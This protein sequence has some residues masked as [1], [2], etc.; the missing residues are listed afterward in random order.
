MSLVE[1]RPQTSGST[2]VSHASR[3]RSK[4]GGLH[5]QVDKHDLVGQFAMAPAT[6]TTVVTTTTT[7]TVKYPPFIMRAPNK[8]HCLDPKQYPLQDSPTPLSLKNIIFKL[9]GKSTTFQEAPDSTMA[10]ELFQEEHKSIQRANGKL[11]TI[12][13]DDGWVEPGPSRP[14]NIIARGR[15]D[16]EPR[17]ASPESIPDHDLDDD[18]EDAA[19]L[20][21]AKRRKIAAP[22]GRPVLQAHSRVRGPHSN[23]ITPESQSRQGRATRRSGRNAIHDVRNAETV[24]PSPSLEQTSTFT[25]SQAASPGPYEENDESLQTDFGESGERMSSIETIRRG[26]SHDTT[27][28]TPPV[29]S[30][31]G[32]RQ[33]SRRA[34]SSIPARLN[35]N[36]SPSAQDGSLPSP[37]LSPVTAAATLQ[38][39]GYFPD[40]DS[41]SE[42]PSP[43]VR[44]AAGHPLRQHTPSRSVGDAVDPSLELSPLDDPAPAPNFGTFS[45]TE[46]P[47]MLDYFQAIPAEL[48][49]YVMH[50][51][52]RRCPKSTLHMVADVV[53]PAL[54]CDFLTALPAEL[55]QTVVRFLDLKSLCKAAQVSKRWRHMINTHDQVWIQLFNADGFTLPEGEQQQA[56]REGWGYQDPHGVNG[57]EMNIGPGDASIKSETAANSPS[58]S[59]SHFPSS[60]GP[61]RRSK[62]KAAPALSTR[63]RQSKRK[64]SSRSSR[65]TSLESSTIDWMEKMNTTEATY[66]AASQAAS[67][68]A[69]AV[70]HPR[71][72][73]PSLQN[74]H[75][76]KSLYRRHY[77]I[78]RNWM[79]EDT[80]PRHIAFRAHDTHVVTCLQ[81][82]T[83]KILTGSDDNNIN[84]YDTKSG[85]LRARLIGHEG[86]VWALQYQGN[87]L[88]SG[89]TDRSVR[90]W[91]IEKGEERQVFRGHTSTVRCLQIVSPVKIG[92][93]AEG[94]PIMT[95]KHPLI[96]TGSRDSTLRV[97]KLPKPDD[98]VFIQPETETDADDCPWFL[99]TLTGHQHSVRAIAAHGDTLVSGSYDCTVRVWKIS[100]GESVLTLRGHA[101]KVYSVVLDHAR[102]RCISGSMDNMVRIWD[103][104][105]GALRYSL[106]GH[107]SLVGLLDLQCDRL[108]SAAAD[109]TLRIWDPENGSC[110][111]TLTAHTGAITCF[112]HDG[113]KVISGSDRTLKLW[114]I[115]RGECV[116]DLLS[117]LSGVWQVRFDERRCVSAVQRDGVTFIEVS[118]Q[119]NHDPFDTDR[120]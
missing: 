50:Q 27:V 14:L 10:L 47:A 90:V 103:L 81:F 35:V 105:T 17:P 100:T 3:P 88:V 116:K 120:M 55:A 75:L 42:Y 62:R 57:Y 19:L 39:G 108:V 18:N 43:I 13:T 37:S 64:R 4:S 109:S 86:G 54:K 22:D 66:K 84:V 78:R 111:A 60:A 5:P 67:Q 89:S 76:F 23:P 7:T 95:P 96:I 87:T 79:H 59:L 80:K 45:L 48:K 15:R 77:L 58:P 38:T 97:W 51:L 69:R 56:Q 28:P 94:K 32:R 85:A 9:G 91:D 44:A 52:L 21:Q 6:Q 102:N 92:E 8:K 110:K 119:P 25:H 106:E 2:R 70:L 101:Q 33:L 115:R 34:L 30:D 12:E 24:L 118:Q 65:E 83:D 107:S 74:L 117:D 104:D 61:L 31:E 53:N 16:L 11:Q 29:E 26:A 49:G 68:A 82:D 72:G 46:I 99:R 40:I 63:Q 41:H 1:K 112:Q 93:N 98:R 20:H 73:L 114:D 113:Q 71:A 36:E